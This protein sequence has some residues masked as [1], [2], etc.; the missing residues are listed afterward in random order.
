[1]R[2]LASIAVVSDAKHETKQGLRLFAV[3]QQ[4]VSVAGKAE[5]DAKS[6]ERVERNTRL[7]RSGTRLLL[8][9]PNRVGKRFVNIL[10]QEIFHIKIK[11][12]HF[13]KLPIWLFWLI[14]IK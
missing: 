13:V 1:M 9:A 6:D 3:L 2:E 8:L 12:L 5:E 11:K 7:C 10:Q 14:R 4:H